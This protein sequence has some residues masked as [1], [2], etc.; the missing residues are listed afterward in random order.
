MVKVKTVDK[1]PEYRIYKNGRLSMGSFS[2]KDMKDFAIRMK[3][4]DSS[5]QIEL[6]RYQ[7]LAKVIL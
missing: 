6:V 3:E 4:N 2:Y 1:N 5:A 7:V